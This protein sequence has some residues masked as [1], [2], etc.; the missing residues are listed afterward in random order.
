[1]F[2]VQ[3]QVNFLTNV[4]KIFSDEIKNLLSSLNVKEKFALTSQNKVSLILTNH[5]RENK[6]KKTVR[7]LR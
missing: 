4:T 5:L 2:Y 1:M 7:L 6:N 3:G